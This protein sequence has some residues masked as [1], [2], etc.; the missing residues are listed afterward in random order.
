M[1]FQRRLTAIL[2]DL[3]LHGTLDWAQ[4]ECSFHK[5]ESKNFDDDNSRKA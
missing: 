1:H 4:K 5:T 3:S 2:R